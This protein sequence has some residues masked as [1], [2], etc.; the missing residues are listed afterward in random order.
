MRHALLALAVGLV[1]C[2]TVTN[3]C[4]TGMSVS[5]ACVDGRTGAQ[6][7]QADGTY[8]ACQCGVASCNASN[9]GGCCDNLGVCQGGASSAACGLG[10]RTCIAC[11]S[12]Q[13]CANGACGAALADAGTGCTACASGELCIQNACAKPRRV[14]KTNA[15][16]TGDLGGL[17]GADAKCANAA[18]IQLRPGTFKA[19]LSDAS[20]NALDRIVDV[21]PWYDFQSRLVFADKAQLALGPTK[22]LVVDE[23]GFTGTQFDVWTGTLIG[24]TRAT[25]HC[26]NWSSTTST[27]Q[28][29]GA[30][31]ETGTWTES[32]VEPCS[33]GKSLYCLEQ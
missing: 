6:T 1:G 19:W 23:R 12:T 33:A 20:T 16:F 18:R 2:G 10:G 5:C 29:G 15:T 22:Q 7:C 8:A 11:G 25:A 24:G 14:F 28:S 32:T 27:G 31:S 9:C 4:T 3:V 30:T 17:A 21:G 13:S 26:T